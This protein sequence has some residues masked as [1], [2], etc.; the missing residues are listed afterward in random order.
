MQQCYC[1]N[2]DDDDDDNVDDDDDD[3][4]D[5]EEEDDVGSRNQTGVTDKLRRLDE[6]WDDILDSSVNCLA[7]SLRTREQ[8]GGGGGKWDRGTHIP[9]E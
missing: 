4:D 7:R 1:Y 2:D 9:S 6:Y 3:D 5:D 8:D